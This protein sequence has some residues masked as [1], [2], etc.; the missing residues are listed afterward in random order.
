VKKKR[1]LKVIH[2]WSGTWKKKKGPSGKRGL[3]ALDYEENRQARKSDWTK[4]KTDVKK[5]W[6]ISL[7]IKKWLSSQIAQREKWKKKS[8]QVGR[9]ENGCTSKNRK[10]KTT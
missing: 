3:Q 9:S 4:D 5:I 2:H 8:K 1:K 7:I 6:H 10:A